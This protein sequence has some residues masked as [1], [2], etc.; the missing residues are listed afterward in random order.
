M[1]SF[2][3]L[4]GR[5]EALQRSQYHI[6]LLQDE[7]AEERDPTVLAD[8]REELHDRLVQLGNTNLRDLN[9]NELTYLTQTARAIQALESQGFRYEIIHQLD[10]IPPS[11]RY[12]RLAKAVFNLQSAL[13]NGN[14]SKG[15]KIVA[16]IKLLLMEVPSLRTP[17]VTEV[18]QTRIHR[19]KAS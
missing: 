4:T 5:L 3:A 10:M 7:I 1:E 8:M 19:R 16:S 18:L 6:D 15:Q 9:P 17:L 2:S 11:A 14:K 12:S 13:R